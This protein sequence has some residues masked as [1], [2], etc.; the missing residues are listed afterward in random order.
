MSFTLAHQSKNQTQDG[1]VTAGR[2][3]KPFHRLIH[4]AIN[5]HDSVI[6]HLQRTIGNQALQRL[7][8]SNDGFD[9]SKIAI[10]PKLKISQPGDRYEQEADRFA[11]Q[12]M[13][14]PISDS[15]SSMSKEE[16]VDR[17]CSAYEMNEQENTEEQELNIG[18]K[19]SS[20]PTASNLKTALEAPNAISNVLSSSGSPLD[21]STRQFM[22]TRFGYDFNN[23]RIHTT[24]Q[25]AK[26]AES[27]NALAYT[28]GNDIVFGEGQFNP[29][30][31]EG[32]KILAHELTHVT[33]QTKTDTPGIQRQV[34]EAI[35]V[36][37]DLIQIGSTF[38]GDIKQDSLFVTG[39]MMAQDGSKV[40]PDFKDS[41]SVTMKIIDHPGLILE[42]LFI[43]YNL[44]WDFANGILNFNFY[45]SPDN[46]ASRFDDGYITILDRYLKLG[47]DL[48][49]RTRVPYIEFNVALYVNWVG[50]G[51]Y[52]GGG[53]IEAGPGAK[54]VWGA[55]AHS[56]VYSTLGKRQ[57]WISQPPGP[58]WKI[59]V[60]AV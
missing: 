53:T 38:V 37:S 8:H 57:Y 45:P 42:D 4:S 19:R 40:T 52:K 23:V 12:V 11:E 33:Q 1:K 32:K 59:E 30:T 15:V 39:W 46:T 9:F 2:T 28:V 50:E 22:E 7:V 58:L 10:Q 13:R 21:P 16:R 26:S 31:Y 24:S 60:K 36:V 5:S 3:S 41:G 49:G 29:H 18:L 47:Y 48:V 44:K 35:G 55:Q 6:V 56:G 20:S 27:L 17:K 43:S 25:A 51:Y 34:K 54:G 14:M